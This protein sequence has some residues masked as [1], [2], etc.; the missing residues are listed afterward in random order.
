MK[1]NYSFVLI[2]VAVI[3]AIFVFKKIDTLFGKAKEIKNIADGSITYNIG[4]D[5]D[6]LLS[7]SGLFHPFLEPGPDDWLANHDENGQTFDEFIAAPRNALDTIRKY[8]Y[9]R[10]LWY[11][12]RNKSP[13]LESLRRYTEAYF[14]VSVKLLGIEKSLHVQFMPRMNPHIGNWQLHAGMI[15]SYLLKHIPI[16][17]YCIIGVTMEDL[18]P[19][20]AWNFVFGYAS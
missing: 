6:S 7:A 19:D 15:M 4:L 11:F 5:S 14:N 16:D 2:A 12:S 18:Y 10:P 17:T 3:A 1:K 13:S 9:I 20:P 8:I